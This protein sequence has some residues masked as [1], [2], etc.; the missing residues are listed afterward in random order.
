MLPFVI[1]GLVTGGVYGLAAVGLTLTYRTSGVF[2]FA[3]GAI[4]SVSAYAFYVLAVQH[5]LPWLWAA[6]LAVFVVGPLSGVLFERLA[7]VI[8]PQNLAVQVTATVGV[9]LMIGALIVLIFGITQ[10][11]RVP[12]FLAEGGTTIGSAH[13]QYADIITFGIAV[14]A[15][16]LLYLLMRF[17]RLGI[18][19]RA[20]VDDPRLVELTGTSATKV[21]RSAW[22]IGMIFASASGVLFAPLLPLEPTLITLLV[23]QAFGAAALGAFRNLP[24]AF[25]G[26]LLVGVL[27]ALSTKWFTTGVLAGLPPAIPFIVLFAVLLVFP[28]RFLKEDSRAVPLRQ[29]DW[30][31]PRSLQFGIGGLLLLFLI[32]VPSFAGIHLTDWTTALGTVIIFLSLGLLV[33]TSG[34]VS[35]CHVAFAAIGVTAFAHLAGDVG[36]PWPLALVGAGLVAVP[37]GALLA[38][39]AIRLTGL[40]LAIATFGFGIALYY[41]FYTSSFMFGTTG[42]GVEVPRPGLFEGD[43]GFYYLVLAITVAVSAMVVLLTR[44]RLGRLLRGLGDSPLALTMTGVSSNV[45]RVIVFCISAF[46]AAVGGALIG[47]G[48]GAVSA[49]SYPPL[50][51]LSYLVLV[52]IVGGRAPWYAFVAGIALIIPPSYLTGFDTAYW[53]Q[54][55]FG[56]SAIV[57][58]LTPEEA[59]G[60]PLPVKR[61]IDRLFGRQRGREETTKPS[62]IPAVEHGVARRGELEVANVTVRYGGVKALDDVSLRIPE[63]TI[64]G[65]IG[66]NGAGKTTC[67]NACSGLTRVQDGQVELNGV[68]LRRLG[69]ARRARVGL[70][71]TFQ[72]VE[73]FDTLSVYE[74]VALGYEGSRGGASPIGQTFARKAERRE[75]EGAAWSALE[76]CGID[77]LAGRR[78]GALSTGQ[79]RLVE[80]ARCLAGPFNILLLDEPSSGLDVNETKAFGDVLERVV[81]DRGVGIFLVEHDMSLVMRICSYIHVL[82]FGKKVFEGPPESVRSSRIVQ[83]TY[84]GDSALEA[85]LAAAADGPA[86]SEVQG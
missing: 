59:R 77:D 10:T 55:L 37:I 86:P 42:G 34:Q 54:L 31:A 56:V 21:R 24:M 33:R 58:A 70:G 80:L 52:M 62:E 4:G 41:M 8:A 27:A 2:N 38:I 57:Y 18:S 29:P 45:T 53:L 46:L 15:T 17:T 39:P 3:Y 43:T 28:K 84:L 79:R 64:T 13:V 65:L 44:M 81:A 35:L 48:Q 14:G 25:L 20:V 76:L 60:I 36:L 67:F 78:A 51:S 22:M 49:S 47:A 74:N 85:D 63:G 75:R 26:G 11:R 61:G 5:D 50:L 73:L 32:L 66:P 9:L 83:E 72:K 23:V 19:M 1:T 7:R 69:A 30:T 6:L 82:D 16:T 71:R 40:Y 12:V 68:A